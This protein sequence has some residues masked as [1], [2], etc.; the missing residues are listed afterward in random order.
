[1]AP[2]PLASLTRRLFP[3]PEIAGFF[4]SHSRAD[5][6]HW[7]IMIPRMPAPFHYADIVVT[8]GS[9]GFEFLF[10]R[11][12]ESHGPAN[13]AELLVASGGHEAI[14]R[15][16]DIEADCRRSETPNEPVRLAMGDV[17]D[18]HGDHPRWSVTVEHPNARLALEISCDEEVTWFARVLGLYQHVGLLAHYEG[19]IDV[20]GKTHS[21]RGPC[22][23]EYAFGRSSAR[24]PG[25]PRIPLRLFNYEVMSLDD[26]RQLLAA[27]IGRSPKSVQAQTAWLKGKGLKQETFTSVTKQILEAVDAETP[28]GRVMRVPRE[29]VC[30]LDGP[31]G[32]AR[33]ECV[34]TTDLSYGLGRGYVAGYD[35]SG[36]LLGQ[37]VSGTGY[38]EY[39][40]VAPAPPEA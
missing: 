3:R 23:F 36:S 27:R 9:P 32:S 19:T 26:G 28:D 17:L 10:T 7:G 12:D 34:L 35:F 16:F 37:S 15:Q 29:W 20:D 24:L 21:V 31:R 2:S 22:S 30:E 8:M 39:V 6:H 14:H 18:L 5:W 1:M 33:L 38:L 11:E 40:D 4:R 13:T 25:G